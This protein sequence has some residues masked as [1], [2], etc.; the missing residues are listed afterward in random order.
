M[1]KQQED[2]KMSETLSK[3]K[4]EDKFKKGQY[5]TVLRNKYSMSYP[6]KEEAL[7]DAYDTID[8]W[9]SSKE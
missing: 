4:M 8:P 2:V 5:K 3:L 6:T 1:K 9:E 7:A